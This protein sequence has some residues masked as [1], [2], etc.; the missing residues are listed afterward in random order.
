MSTKRSLFAVGAAVLL[1]GAVFLQACGVA[2]DAGVA[3]E[4]AA[5]SRSPI[6][7]GDVP[8]AAD[9]VPVAPADGDTVFVDESGAVVPTAPPRK[10]VWACTLVNGQWYCRWVYPSAGAVAAAAD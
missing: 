3:D 2:E 9:P 10:R 8:T 1:N 7:S 5:A 4:A 6:M